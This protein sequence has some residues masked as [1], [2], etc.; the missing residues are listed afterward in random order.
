MNHRILYTCRRTCLPEKTATS[1]KMGIAD[2]DTGEDQ[3]IDFGTFGLADAVAWHYLA[4]FPDGR[5]LVQSHHFLQKLSREV[6]FREAVA[7]KLWMYDVLDG[8]LTPMDVYE[9]GQRHL[10]NGIAVFP[11]AERLL[12]GL[13]GNG[14]DVLW[15]EMNL[16]GTDRVQITQP[17]EGYSHTPCLSPDGSRMATEFYLPDGDTRICVMNRN[18]RNR[19]PFPHRKGD[20][21]FLPRWSPDGNWILYVNYRHDIDPDHF[22]ADLCLARSDGT[23]QRFLTTGRPF[24]LS[25]VYGNTETYGGG[26]NISNWSPDGQWVTFIRFQPGSRTAWEP[27]PNPAVDD[28]WGRRYVPDQARGGSQICLLNPCT[29]EIREVTPMREKVWDFRAAWHP[30]GRRL[31]F[32]RAS[33]GLPAELW[34]VCADGSNPKFLTKG[35]ADQGADH[36]AWFPKALRE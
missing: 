6:S 30:S 5:V 32:C 23:E 27:D 26:S 21:H 25:A 4:M 36:P 9:G 34:T 24:W 18:G 20:C 10:I 13:Q 1:E 16:D 3:C 35:F 12:V 15:T 19:I 33:V 22:Q 14:A 17:G 28:H 29:G 31:A 11:G 8:S 2:A 7:A